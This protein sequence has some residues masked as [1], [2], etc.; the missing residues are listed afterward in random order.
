MAETL[1]VKRQARRTPVNGTR[2]RLTVRGKDPAYEY[3]IV[4]DTD[5]R[6]Q[7]MIDR[8]YE[9]VKDQ[10]VQIGDKRVAT[11]VAEGTPQKISVGGGTQAYVMRIKKEFYEEDKAAKAQQ[12]NELESSMKAEARQNTD[13][14]KLSVSRE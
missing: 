8:G 14:G 9:I 6:I 1:T 2:N 10:N 3:R 5:D 13:Y 7:E 11:P 12:V 4:N